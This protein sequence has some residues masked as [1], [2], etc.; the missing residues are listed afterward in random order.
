MVKRGMKK[1]RYIIRAADDPEVFCHLDYLD[2]KIH[3][4]K[5]GNKICGVSG[6]NEVGIT[7]LYGICD[8]VVNGRIEKA[9]GKRDKVMINSSPHITLI[10]PGCS[11][12]VFAC[13]DVKISISVTKAGNGLRETIHIP[14]E[15]MQGRVRGQGK[16]ERIVY[17]LVPDDVD[18]KLMIYE[19]Y[20][21]EGN[22]SS[23]PPHKHD[24][25]TDDERLL[26][27]VYYFTF[28]PPEGFALVWLCDDEGTMDHAYAVKNGDLE[29]IPNGYHTMVVSPGYMCSTHAVM[30]G[31]TNEW[32]I[33][34]KEEYV[35]L[36]DW[37]N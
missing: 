15:S 3:I 34:F 5:V 11:Y 32:K 25:D 20:T 12:E 28:D 2:F 30:A 13:T 19:V 24:A 1:D 21:P 7:I 35:H 18:T 14:A 22:W 37:Q 29:A 36:F 4:L 6:E 33:K 17:D 16:T 23:F 31:P 27:E 9:V 8:I 26:Q 10:A